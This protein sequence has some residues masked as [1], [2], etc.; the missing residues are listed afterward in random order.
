MPTLYI[1]ESLFFKSVKESWDNDTESRLMKVFT[2]AEIVLWDE[3]SIYDYTERSWIYERVYAI[4]EQLAEADKK[5]I[6]ATNITNVRKSG[7]K[8]SYSIEGR[9]GKRIWARLQRRCTRFLEMKN[10]PFF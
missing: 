5:V 7:D 2:L 10:E 3:F 1:N 8:D 9:V 6:F 4:V